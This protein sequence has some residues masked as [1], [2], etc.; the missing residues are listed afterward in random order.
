MGMEVGKGRGYVMAEIHLSV[1]G[2]WF[3]GLLQ[4][5]G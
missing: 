2:E 1:V 4:E 5:S 3:M